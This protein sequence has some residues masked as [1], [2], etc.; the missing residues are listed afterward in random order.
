MINFKKKVLS[1]GLR[2]VLAPMENTEAATLSVLVGAGS[3][4]ETK[5]ING[6]SHFLEHLFFKGTKSRPKPGQVFK[7]LDKIGAAYNA[8][9]SKESTGFWVKSATEDFDIG[10]DIVSDILLEPLFKP[11]EIEKERGVILQ[12][13][14]MI[15]DDPMRKVWD[16]FENVFYGDQPI[17]WDIAGNK[18]TIMSI[19]RKNIIGYRNK[20]YLSKNMVVAAAGKINQAEV[21][22]KIE[23]VFGRIK[24]GKNSGRKDAKIF[25]RKPEVKILNKDSDQ[26]HLA[27]GFHAYDMYDEKMYALNLLSVILGGNFSS[28]LMMEI[29]EKLG[30]AYY[31]FSFGDQNTDCGSIGMGAGVGHDNLEKTVKKIFEVISKIKSNGVSK[32]DLSDGKSFIRGQRVL[33]MESSSEIASFCSGRELF[34]KK[35]L[36][37]EELDKKFEKVSQN[38]IL[39][40]A[41]EVFRPG[42]FNM[43]VIGKHDDGLEKE[44][45]CRNLFA[46]I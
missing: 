31:V 26:S 35:I 37:P 39:K 32:S 8:F 3:R 13:I 33:K 23:K 43:A 36:Q 9:T 45:F 19:N 6:V 20:N 18:E 41:N 24:K 5:N 44:K 2:V 4:Y 25:Q 11:E 42:R 38:D 27:M 30:L 40:V 29:R 1:N 34:Y 28:K 46:K 12:E 10:L 14:N 7:D 16:I 21:F 17:G 22:K 15:E